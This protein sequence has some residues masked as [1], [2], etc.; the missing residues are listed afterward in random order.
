MQYFVIFIKGI[1]IGI[2]NVIPGVSGGTFALVLGIYERLIK[3]LKAFDIAA[4]RSLLKH[5]PRAYKSESRA[6]LLA[7]IK[8]TD[9]VFLGVLALGALAAIKGFAGLL[10]FLLSEHPMPTLAFFVGLIIPSIAL[11]AK[12]MDRKGPVQILAVVLGATLTVLVSMGQVSSEGAEPALWAIFLGGAVA[13]AAMILPGI[14]GSFV[15]LVLGLY[16]PTLEHIHH[17]TP[18]GLIFLAVMSAG[19]AFGLV[20]ISRLMAWLLAHQRATT[21]AFLLGLIF[22]SFYV[23]WPFKDYAASRSKA[24]V[25]SQVKAAQ[26]LKLAAKAEPVDKEKMSIR[27]A[28]A[29]NRLPKTAAETALPVLMLLLGFGLAYGMGR[30]GGDEGSLA[31]GKAQKDA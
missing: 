14:S 16:Q 5:L 19:F 24:V 7:E 9:L 20:S 22:G 11:T 27:I 10:Q 29:P 30:F 23:L 8:R 12:L 18:H 31:D 28:T 3:A 4:A 13:I 17:I 26:D 15:L 6:V 25:A 21:L 1:L 2:A